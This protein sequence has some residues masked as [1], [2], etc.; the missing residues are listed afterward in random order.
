MAATNPLFRDDPRPAGRG[1]AVLGTVVGMAC[2]LGIFLAM[3]H[4]HHRVPEAPPPEIADLKAIA[5]DEPPPPPPTAQPDETAPPETILTGLEAAATESPVKLVALLPQLDLATLSPPEAPAATIQVGRLYTEL[6]PKFDATGFQDHVYQMEELD[7]IPRVLHRVTPSI[8]G[9]VLRQTPVLR[10]TV[11]FVVEPN[12]EV[13][14]VRVSVSSGNEEFDKIIAEVIAQWSFS[15]GVRRG[16]K[17]RTLMQQ[18]T[19]VKFSG[20]NLFSL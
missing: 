17:V 8:S 7:Q 6:R 3:A 13:R 15:P 11:L 12:G 1:T 18:M 9:E 2:T 5:V 4:L 19:Y 16:K 14:N 20:G 10:T